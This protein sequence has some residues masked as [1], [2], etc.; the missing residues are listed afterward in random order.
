MLKFQFHNNFRASKMSWGNH[1]LLYFV[2][3]TQVF[4]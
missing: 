2:F 3:H 4:S 1:D